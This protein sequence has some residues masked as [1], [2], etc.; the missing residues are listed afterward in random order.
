MLILV[1]I[2]YISLI[3]NVKRLL[4]KVS[5][6]YKWPRGGLYH[7]HCPI[8]GTTWVPLFTVVSDAKMLSARSVMEITS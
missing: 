4:H 2:A 6:N 1:A 3:T 8:A 7:E 5:W